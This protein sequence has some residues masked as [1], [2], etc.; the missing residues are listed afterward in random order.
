MTEKFL[1]KWNDFHSNISSLFS[2]L[3]SED[4]LH[5]VTLVSDDGQHVNAHKLVPSACS[6]YCKDI[7]KK[8]K[9]SNPYLCLEGVSSKNISDILEYVYNGQVQIFQ[10]DL[11]QFLNI[12]QRFKLNG[13]LSNSDNDI[14]EE[15]KNEK[16]EDGEDS[17]FK[18]VEF[19]MEEVDQLNNKINELIKREENGDNMCSLCGKLS[20]R[21]NMMRNHIETHL[22][23]L[24]FPCNFC[25]AILRSRNSLS[26]HKYTVHK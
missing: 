18:N 8:T 7:F 22:E 12:A 23:G 9:T 17:S 21:L 20:K 4:Y 3:R 1:L 5:D 11:N 14:M 16:V 13:L 10:A 25:P 19:S 2:T 15:C 26:R 24:S 6:D